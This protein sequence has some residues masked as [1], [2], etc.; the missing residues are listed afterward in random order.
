MAKQFYKIEDFLDT[1]SSAFALKGTSPLSSDATEVT[2]CSSANVLAEIEDN[3]AERSIYIKET[4]TP[5][6]SFAAMWTRW[7]ARRGD[8]LAASWEAL[9]TRYKPLENY[10]RYEAGKDTRTITPAETTRT[11]TP[12][13]TTMTV[14]PAETTNTISPAETTNTISPAETTN[15]ITP[16]ETTNTNTPAETT[17]TEAITN[18][19]ASPGRVSDTSSK[20]YAF[21][22]SSAVPVSEEKTTN[23][24]ETTNAL[25]VQHAGSEAVTVQH[26]GTDAL[27]VQQAG[28]DALTVQQA[29][30]EALTVQEPETQAMTV[31]EP[32][33]EVLTVQEPETDEVE[34][35]KHTYGNIG[36][37]S[38]MDLIRQEME[39]DETDF[40]YK[41]ICEFIN[42]YTVYV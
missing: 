42:L 26:A 24:G 5:M 36:V 29:G 31:Q 14:T 33:T 40:V 27:T 17:N 39:I 7:I 28:T 3:F 15:T 4:E 1:T 37:T 41:A 16:A 38:A 23:T 13:E 10:D 12:A 21:N 8:R 9:H 30:T 22:S 18:T 35:G 32:G 20:V 25:T 11:T 34:Y 19:Q 6:T 2:M